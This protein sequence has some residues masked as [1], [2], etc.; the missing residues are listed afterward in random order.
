[1]ETKRRS[2]FTLLLV[3]VLL[4]GLSFGT[5]FGLSQALSGGDSHEIPREFD[6]LREVWHQL[7]QDYVNKDTLDPQKL[8]QGAIEGLI[9]ALGDPYTY[10]LDA[11]TYELALSS[12]EG[13]LEG[14][15][16]IVT[17]EDGWLTVISPIANSPAEEQGIRAGDRI[18]EI[19]GEDTSAMTLTEAVLRIRGDQGTKVILLVLHQGEP[20]PVEMEIT[21]EEIKLDSVYLELLPGN[22]AHITITHFTLRT[23]EELDT[24]LTEALS[25]GVAGIVLDLRGNPGGLLN[26]AVD[27][28]DQ[29]LDDGIILYEAN[30][31]GEV[32]KEFK[33]SPGG[34][35]TDLPLTVLVNGGSASSSEV[36]AGALQDHRR[37]PLI[38]TTTFGKGS[39]QAI[40]ELS[41]GSALYVTAA[42]WLTPNGHQ[43]EGQGLTPD[44]EV[45]ITEEDIAQGIDPQLERAIDYIETGE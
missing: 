33:A 16:A 23:G 22:I 28:A 11:E 25:D 43:I 44:F 13:S 29:F 34:L 21:R 5:G 6:A 40:R 31:E 20:E 37:A 15:G 8:T 27:V 30:G 10:Y 4:L 3:A 18:L 42:S 9:E 35:A 41:G 24:I 19:D 17:I 36:L 32:I 45:P 39:V 38:G 12:L 2:S 14:I 7:S 1:M 26:G